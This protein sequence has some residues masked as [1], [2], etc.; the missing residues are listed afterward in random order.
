MHL[1]DEYRFEYA[2]NSPER[3]GET[4]KQRMGCWVSLGDA[5]SEVSAEIAGRSEV[6]LD[7]N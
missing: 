5:A 7:L 3:I 6:K 1:F 2:L 4:V